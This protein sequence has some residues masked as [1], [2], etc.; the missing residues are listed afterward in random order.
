MNLT[1]DNLYKLSLLVLIV[2]AVVQ[3][4]GYIYRKPTIIETTEHMNPA[5][6][7]H[8]Y[9]SLAPKPDPNNPIHFYVKEDRYY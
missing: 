4:Y 5:L 6:L 7:T 8:Q 2:L 3:I 9:E 1:S